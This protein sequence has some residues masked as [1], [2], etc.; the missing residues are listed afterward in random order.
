LAEGDATIPVSRQ[1]ETLA[2]ELDPDAVAG[3]GSNDVECVVV[4][5]V[6]RDQE[7]VGD[8]GLEEDPTKRFGDMPGSLIG[9]K[10]DGDSR[11]LVHRRRLITIRGI[12]LRPLL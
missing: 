11:G 12:A 8:L 1:A 2:V 9:G 4:R 5:P 3:Q 6:V 10:G 7:F